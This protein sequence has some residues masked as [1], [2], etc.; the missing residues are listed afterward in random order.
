MTDPKEPW[1]FN[2]DVGFSRVE[3]WPDYEALYEGAGEQHTAV[4]EAS[5]SYL[6]SQE[7]LPSI[8]EYAPDARFIVMLRFPP[9][10]VV[11]LHA[12]DFG[13][14]TENRNFIEAWGLQQRRAKGE[15]LPR[16]S[17]HAD[18]FQYGEKCQVGRHI[19][20]LFECVS[21]DRVL[22]LFL[23][24]V[25]AD[26][27]GQWSRVIDF[28]GVT[29]YW[30]DTFAAKNERR[31]VKSMALKQVFSGLCYIKSKL[32]MKYSFGVMSRVRDL[33][34]GKANHKTELVD[35]PR[36]LQGELAEYFAREVELV[37]KKLGHVPDSWHEKLKE[38]RIAGGTAE[39]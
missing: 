23:E 22:V 20:R 9:D 26:V 24:D 13:A 28:L 16:F 32:G 3:S 8:L 11:S 14:G 1:F 10:M 33:N 35:L 7:A 29:E 39:S 21:S 12:Q 38:L 27:E 4:G 31:Y 25:I 2:T 37:E 34:T 15:A 18:M 6:W 30:P 17:H 5:T 36:R 19:S